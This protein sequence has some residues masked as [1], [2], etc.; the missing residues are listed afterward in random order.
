MRELAL[1]T[2]REYRMIQPGEAVA[3]GCS[4]GADST[5]LLLLLKEMSDT[6]GCVLSAAHLNHCLRGGES[7][8]DERFVRELAE[9]LGVP[10][11]VE[12]ADVSQ[13]ARQSRTNPEAQARQLRLRFFDSLIEAGRADVVALAHTADD[14]AETLLQRLLRGAGTRGLSGIHPVIED[15]AG[16]RK[17]IRP[18]LRARRAAVRQ[19]LEERAERWREDSSNQDLRRVRNRIRHQLLPLLEQ[20]NPRI[21]ETLA[22]T[23]ALAREEEGFWKS[24]LRPIYE[25]WVRWENGAAQVELEALRQAPPA[26]AY[27]VLRLAVGR[28]TQEG[29][30][31]LSSQPRPTDFLHIKQLYDWSL[32][33]QSGQ[34]FSLPRKVEARKEF[35]HLILEKRRMRTGGSA[36]R[37]SYPVKVP[38]MVRVAE[39]ALTLRFELIALEERQPRYNERG[40]VLLDAKLAGSP[41]L[42]R[43]WQPGDAYR[44][45]GHRSPR[46]LQD[47]FQ[48]HR[49]PVRD[50]AGWPVLCAGDQIVWVR[51]LAVASGYS[52][53][54]DSRQAVEIHEIC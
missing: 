33:G 23:A 19:W 40:S 15:P 4:G 25:S 36:V 8:G 45:E 35:S 41:L 18:L 53:S 31:E 46:K 2:I 28:I 29:V 52:P 30:R 3:V 11:F 14:Q 54:P 49:I 48:R 6:L 32:Q 21:V 43:N 16:R 34:R 9:R 13:I 5:A 50:R 20:F 22:H 47:L 38:G 12:R 37:Y 17:L 44:P 26:V 24:Y 10:C 7:E 1:E 42:V 51:G 39:I 27:R